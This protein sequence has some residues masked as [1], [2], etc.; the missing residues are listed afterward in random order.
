VSRLEAWFDRRLGPVVQELAAR[1]SAESEDPFGPDGAVVCRVPLHGRS[2][3]VES[4]APYRR[5]VV[6]RGLASLV[7]LGPRVYVADGAPG[8]LFGKPTALFV[9]DGLAR[10]PSFSV[11]GEGRFVVGGVAY[12][13]LDPGVERRLAVL[14]ADRVPSPP[15][16]QPPPNVELLSASLA[17][18]FPPT[19]LPNPPAGSPAPT[20][21]PNAPTAGCTP[22][23]LFYGLCFQTPKA[24]DEG[25][26]EDPLSQETKNVS[27]A[28]KARGYS[29]ANGLAGASAPDGGKADTF[30]EMTAGLAKAIAAQT[31]FCT[32]PDD[33]LVIFVAAH[34]YAGQF[35]PTGEVA[36]HFDA[37]GVEAPKGDW[38]TWTAFLDA[39]AAIPQVAANPQK[40]F[41]IVYSC[42]SGRL[43]EG[44]VIP[45]TLKGMHAITGTATSGQYAGQIRFSQYLVFALGWL[46]AV[47][48]DHLVK[49]MKKQNADSP[50]GTAPNGVPFGPPTNGDLAGC[51]FRMTLTG[52]TFAGADLGAKWRYSLAAAGV[53]TEIPAH[54]VT[55]STGETR[56]DVI[57][58]RLY[59]PCPSPVVFSVTCTA[60]SVGSAYDSDGKAS[61]AIDRLCDGTAQTASCTVPVSA[62]GYGTVNVTFAFSIATTC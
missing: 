36:M 19:D 61:V 32:C 60:V 16:V 55:V 23:L 39:L 20:P 5:H 58:D 4:V 51:R 28:F 48:W 52:V 2:A 26:I 44:G 42:R 62:L 49:L 34:G 13:S 31:A 21:V 18:P 1:G 14:N 27:D 59:G 43:W 37:Q 38:V 10:R 54:Q 56:T 17:S 3:V 15:A 7:G 8:A 30:A 25:T 11:V 22:T 46:K 35:N 57:H 24:V 9:F 53:T 45:P 41:L 33:Q 50:A 12:P 6:R 40:V 29:I 47:N